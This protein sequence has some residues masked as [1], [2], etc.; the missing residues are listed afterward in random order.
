MA[1]QYLTGLIVT[2]VCILSS[3]SSIVSYLQT[4]QPPECSS[5][6]QQSKLLHPELRYNAYRQ[7]FS[8]QNLSMSQLLRTV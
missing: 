7:S 4:S 1:G 8:A 2:Y 6:K 5:T 3:G